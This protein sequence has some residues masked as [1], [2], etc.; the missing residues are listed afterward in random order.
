M[1]INNLEKFKREKKEFLKK[2]DKSRKGEIDEKIKPLID[3]INDIDYYY[4]TSSCSGRIMIYKPGKRKQETEWIMVSHEEIKNIKDEYI[5]DDY[6]FKMEGPII[7]IN[8]FNLDYAEKIVDLFRSNGWKKT[9]IITLKRKIIVEVS[10]PLLIHFPLNKNNMNK[11]EFMKKVIIEANN[12][13]RKGWELIEKARTSINELKKE[14]MN[15]Q[16]NL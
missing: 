13:L 1:S 3:T 15:D 6:W 9:G 10:T 4:T 7:H 2:P 16:K 14:L 5:K 8:C 12:K 11:N